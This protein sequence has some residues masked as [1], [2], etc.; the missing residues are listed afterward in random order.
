MK[1]DAE[2]CFAAQN[3][4]KQKIMS[5]VHKYRIKI[6]LGKSFYN[7]LFNEVPQ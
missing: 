1:Q 6:Y 4:S 7:D 3:S 2:Q 5:V